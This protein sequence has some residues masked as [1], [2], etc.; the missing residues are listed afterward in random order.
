MERD[1]QRR[2]AGIRRAG[3]RGR[4]QCRGEGH[5]DGLAPSDHIVVFA[6]AGAR[7]CAADAPPPD[8]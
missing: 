8:P 5:R 6:P 4:E 1:L 3:G 7:P 2:D